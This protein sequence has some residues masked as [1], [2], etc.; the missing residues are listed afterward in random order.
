MPTLMVGPSLFDWLRNRLFCLF[1][2]SRFSKQ[3]MR[4]VKPCAPICIGCL[5]LVGCGKSDAGVELFPVRGKLL[6]GGKPLANALVVLHPKAQSAT[7][8]PPA[9]AQT[10][11]DGNFALSTFVAQDGA[12]A[13]E[14][15]MT[16]QAYKLERVGEGFAPGPNILP[17][18]LSTPQ[19]TDLFITVAQTTNTLEPIELRRTR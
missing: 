17:P 11:A 2:T 13:G 4:F 14:F 9:R 8:V 16:I 18:K 5:L 7:T 10:D 15:A 1:R 3:S 19:S 12:P 6:L